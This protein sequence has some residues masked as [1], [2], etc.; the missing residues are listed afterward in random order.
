MKRLWILIVLAGCPGR[1]KS[2]P[3]PDLGTGG[4]HLPPDDIGDEEDD[5]IQISEAE[6]AEDLQQL[7][8]NYKPLEPGDQQ[9]SKTSEGIPLDKEQ[10]RRVI[11]HHTEPIR[12]CYEKQHKATPEIRGVVRVRFTIDPAGKVPE[13]KARGIHPNVEDC[14]ETTFRQFLFPAPPS[15]VQVTYPFAFDAGG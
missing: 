14:L 5:G 4:D 9:G 12:S 15:N 2:V 13:A 11:R 3:P 10:I 1:T 6:S 8:R 7:G